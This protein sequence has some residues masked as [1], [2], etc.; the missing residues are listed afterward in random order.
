VSSTVC[1]SPLAEVPAGHDAL[2]GRKLPAIDRVI[3]RYVVHMTGSTIVGKAVAAGKDPIRRCLDYYCGKPTGSSHYLIDF[4]GH[5]HALTDE[6]IRI[7]HVGVTAAERAA[8][9][10]GSWARGA[11]PK[12]PDVEP[13]SPAAVDAWHAAWPH[14]HSPQHL[15]GPKSVNDCSVASEMPPAGYH[16]KGIWRPLP[17]MELWPGTR[18]TL[19]QHLAVAELAVDLAHRH[20][21][22][23]TW[24]VDPKGGP[25]TPRVLGHEDVDLFGRADAGGG[26][27]P[28]ALRRS[29][30][31]DWKAVSMAI[32]MLRAGSPRQQALETLRDWCTVT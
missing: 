14:Y 9:L 20:R 30:R 15:F 23:S 19:E 24:T 18:H 26:W 12:A 11:V 17:G 32:A 28:G 25:R 7:G 2:R 10:D 22:P 8:Y 31:W 29:P 6:R 21:W 27:D 13:I 4:A 3:E 5:I 16:V 1:C